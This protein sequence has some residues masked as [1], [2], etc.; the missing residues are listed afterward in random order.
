[1][2]RAICAHRADDPHVF[3][4]D[5]EGISGNCVL[6]ADDFH[7]EEFKTPWK[8]TDKVFAKASMIKWMSAWESHTCSRNFGRLVKRASSGCG[9]VCS[10]VIS[11]AD[12]KN[13]ETGRVILIGDD[14]LISGK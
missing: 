11:K 3:M 12:Q 9:C 13:V 6:K 4:Y 14:D 10:I 5:G 1:M 7:Q 2:T 8:Y